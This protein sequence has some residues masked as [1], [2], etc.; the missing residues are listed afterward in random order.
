MENFDQNRDEM[1]LKQQ[2]D[3]Q[4]D[5][6]TNTDLVSAKH[7]LKQLEVDFANDE[8]FKFKIIKIGDKYS[9]FR[10]TRPDGNCFFR[11]VGFRLFE[12]MMED[13]DE[14]SKVK[15]A[16]EGSKDEMVKLGMPEF[17]VEDFFDN[18]MDTLEKLAGDEKMKL[19]ELEETF[20]N[21]GLSNYLVVFLRLLTSKQ[22]QIEGEFYQNFMEG[23]RTVAEF[24]S[25]EVEPMYR[26][27]DHIHIIGL[28][29]AAGISVRVVYLDRGT[30]D[31]PVHHDFPEGTEPKIHILYR[32]GHYDILYL[33][34]MEVESVTLVAEPTKD[35]KMEVESDIK[36]EK[37]IG[38]LD[39][40]VIVP[41]RTVV[42]QKFN[43]L[44]TH[45]LNPSKNLQL[46]R[47]LINLSGIVGKTFGTTFKM[48][49]DH[50]NNKC[51]KLE[52]AEEVQN[53]EALFMNGESGEDNRD[54]QNNESSQKLSKQEIVKMRE[55]GVDGKEIVEK[56][57][58]NSETFQNK[59]KF[60]QAKFLK[61]KAKKYH[62]YILIRKPSIRLLMEI[63]YKADPM[64]L[65]NL[66]EDSLAQILNA[67]NVH[68]GG[69]YLVY[70]TGAQGIVVASVLERVGE[71]G[72]VVHIY[73]TGQPQTNC[74]SAM[75][76]SQE[77]LDNLKV[78]NIQHLR[79]LEQGQDILVNRFPPPTNGQNR[80]AA[81]G[82]GEPPKKK[83]HTDNGKTEEKP[84][85]MNLREQSVA[86]F[87]LIK[88]E[89]YD[90]LIIVC[91]QHPS[92][93]LTYLSKFIAPSRPFT[94]YSAYKEPLL[95]AYMAVK[96]SG[97]AINCVL[98]ETW[99]RYHQVLP[100]RT[101]PTVNMS[102][103]GGY[104]L[105]GIFIEK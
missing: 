85:R 56:L 68:S 30:G 65:M 94:V 74:L 6:A 80:D 69:K 20:N 75:D 21:E 35:L 46:G 34:T 87:N 9:E 12:L 45:L 24:C 89:P 61:K 4:K 49:S 47:D 32:P 84:F 97:C 57:I 26:E 67:T 33:K 96:E 88:S 100:E 19:E 54:L 40:E 1:I 22:L 105:T 79:S 95:E 101:H 98:S 2:E 3:I 17:T 70:E 7:P 77:I 102:G 42:L 8:V 81:G 18:F 10:R 82:D 99:L 41:G 71:K 59:T 29:A 93:L 53:F 31:N 27:S 92:A 73:Q 78:I 51:F 76:F 86:T 39:R 83:P 66:R 62:Q 48:V 43:Y 64:K 16:V 60:S 63:H 58:E 14:F 15:K 11:A 104:I 13:L 23:G 37:D 90:G 28:T 50:Q 5:I 38:I 52:V 25:T 44:R 91:K 72:K 55:D 36:T 103:G